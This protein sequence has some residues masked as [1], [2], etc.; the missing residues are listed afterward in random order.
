MYKE[1]FKEGKRVT[2]MVNRIIQNHISYFG[3]G[4]IVEIVPELSSRGYSKAF[5]CT[6][7]NLVKLG[8]VK[9]I[10]DL[11]DKANFGYEVFAGT[12]PGLKLDN[13]KAGVEAYK[14]CGADCMVS[15]GGGSCIDAGK[16]IGL[17]INNP[18]FDDVRSLEGIPD[19]VFPTVFTVAVPTGAGTGAEVS[20]YFII[21]DTENSRRL[22]CMDENDIPE[23]VV[24]DPEMMYTLPESLTGT[25]GM[26]SIAHA[27]EAYISQGA[28]IF[29]DISSIEAI[30]LLNEYIRPAM[31][32]EPAARHGMAMGQ[33]SVGMGYANA[34]M[35]LCMS[36]A[37][38]LT[39]RYG[40]PHSEASAIVLPR[41]I[42]FNASSCGKRLHSVAEALN[43]PAVG[44]MSDSAVPQVLVP[45]LQNLNKDMGIPNDLKAY[46]KAE[47]IPDIAQAV[48]FDAYI[49]NNPK[50]ASPDDIE[51]IL[52]KLV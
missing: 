1:I 50:D 22:V 21:T 20:T 13:V 17:I 18:S 14:A 8:I 52:R 26:G 33:Y 42:E 40:V 47:D 25:M 31:R 51:G 30:R 7:A 19:T 34:G 15:I 23:V 41:V 10:T 29:S 12:E 39:V 27:I 45:F 49:A 6:D 35:G 5:I 37:N 36:I 9:R 32:N 4:A 28:N 44:S 46:L 2:E 43:I 24:V 3:E 11:M 48:C 16:A 38:V